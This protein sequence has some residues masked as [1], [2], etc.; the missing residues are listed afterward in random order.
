MASDD[1]F[2]YTSF[3]VR[4]WRAGLAIITPVKEDI[5]HQKTAQDWK[6]LRETTRGTAEGRANK[7]LERLTE[8]DAMV[9][10]ECHGR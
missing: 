3:D 8:R 9:E 4:V 5:R 1:V 10:S 7:A 6:Y 2:T